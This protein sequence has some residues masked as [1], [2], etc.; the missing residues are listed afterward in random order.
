MGD[1]VP[2]T[3][4]GKGECA[5]TG[6]QV[7]RGAS[8]DERITV[9]FEQHY[10]KLCRLAAL[11]IG[12]APAAEEV[13]QEAFLQTFAGW[14]RV[15]QPE[16]AEFYLRAGVVNLCR[17]RLRR[18]ASEDRGNRI[19]WDTSR[20]RSLP[21]GS[22]DPERAGDALDVLDAVRSLPDRQREAIVLRYYLDLPENEIASVLK[23]AVGTVKSQLSKAKA[24]LARRLGESD[25]LL[26]E[27]GLSSFPEERG[28][29]VSCEEESTGGKGA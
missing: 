22:E 17:T 27:E 19:S 3:P 28:S 23:C 4:S 15:R 6:E 2:L 9:L 10:T 24:T 18:R 7:W 21:G 8:R 11:L 12:D 29:Q 13:V 14:W 1:V 26:G 25:E 16:R 5:A 20:P